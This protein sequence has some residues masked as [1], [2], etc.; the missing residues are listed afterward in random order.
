MWVS[1]IGE[2]DFCHVSLETTELVG[3]LKSWRSM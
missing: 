1:D 2:L 3:V